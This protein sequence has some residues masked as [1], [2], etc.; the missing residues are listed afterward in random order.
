MILKVGQKVL[1][2]SMGGIPGVVKRVEIDG[3]VTERIAVTRCIEVVPMEPEYEVL[4]PLTGPGVRTSYRTIKASP[5][6]L[7]PVDLASGPAREP[8]P[9]GKPAGMHP[10]F[11]PARG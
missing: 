4:I 9:A 5:D 2:K 11:E 6:E 8:A 7:E 1:V 10:A 3:H